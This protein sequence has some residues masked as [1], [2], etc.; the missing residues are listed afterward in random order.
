MAN[1]AS[2]MLAA[3]SLIPGSVTVI[4]SQSNLLFMVNPNTGL[5]L[6]PPVSIGGPIIVAFVAH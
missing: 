3:P 4:G 6:F 5:R 2:T 1:T